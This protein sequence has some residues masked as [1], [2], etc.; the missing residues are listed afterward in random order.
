MR[1]TFTE[2]ITNELNKQLEVLNCAFRFKLVIE[3]YGEK[4]YNPHIK[5]SLIN[6]YFIDS[7]SLTLTDEFYKWL[8]QLCEDNWDIH[9]SYN[10]TGNIIWAKEGWD[11]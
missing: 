4:L 6:N 11:K 5:I 8:E 9:L 10:N 3:E 2:E 1:K 7:F